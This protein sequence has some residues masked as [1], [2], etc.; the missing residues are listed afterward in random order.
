MDLDKKD[1]TIILAAHVY[2]RQTIDKKKMISGHH[3]GL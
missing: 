1:S 2:R 3:L